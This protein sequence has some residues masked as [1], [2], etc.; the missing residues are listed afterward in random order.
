MLS[1][2]GCWPAI[3]K[4]E[5]CLPATS[6]FQYNLLTLTNTIL[7][8]HWTFIT[9]SIYDSNDLMWNSNWNESR[10]WLGHHLLIIQSQFFQSKCVF[11]F[12]FFL[13]QTFSNYIHNTLFAFEWKKRNKQKTMAQNTYF[14][15][16]LPPVCFLPQ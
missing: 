4:W 3:G 11:F 9:R 10:E 6:P 14:I 5:H 15:S 16:P 7:I 2:W 12:L 1:V 13:I 8:L